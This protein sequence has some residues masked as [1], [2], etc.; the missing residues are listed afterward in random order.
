M[1]SNFDTG[2]V[3]KTLVSPYII[4]LS[5]GAYRKLLVEP[6]RRFPSHLAIPGQ[7]RPLRSPHHSI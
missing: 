5:S 6:A 1:R 2:T 7:D 3:S 4:T